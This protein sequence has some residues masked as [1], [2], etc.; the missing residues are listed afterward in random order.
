MAKGAI[1]KRKK[2]A[3][4]LSKEKYDSRPYWKKMQDA[5]KERAKK[6]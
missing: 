4:A 1:Q 5:A 3:R 2:R 6:K